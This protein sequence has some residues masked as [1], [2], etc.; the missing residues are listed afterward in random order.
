MTI[1]AMKLMTIVIIMINFTR[2][3]ADTGSQTQDIANARIP[4]GSRTRRPVN[5][6]PNGY[7]AL[8]LSADA[9]RP[10]LSPNQGSFLI[11]T[12]VGRVVFYIV[13]C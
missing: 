10:P 12:A 3:H 5:T 7:S 1:T 2:A 6:R 8:A 11:D 13:C 4:K 9:I